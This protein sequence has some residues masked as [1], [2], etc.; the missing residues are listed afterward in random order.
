MFFSS[1][2]MPLWKII[3]SYLDIVLIRNLNVTSQLTYTSLYYIGSSGWRTSKLAFLKVT[4]KYSIGLP[5]LA[6]DLKMILIL[7][8]KWW[9]PEKVDIKF[10]ETTTKFGP[11]ESLTVLWKRKLIIIKDN[12]MINI[13]LPLLPRP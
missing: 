9:I 13:W 3:K 5:I 12:F 7:I 4:K 8:W 6:N 1:L 11:F 10:L 2:L